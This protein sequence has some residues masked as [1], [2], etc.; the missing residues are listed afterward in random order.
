[1]ISDFFFGFEEQSQ[2]GVSRLCENTT[3]WLK[4]WSNKYE[5]WS[6][7][8]SQFSVSFLSIPPLR[9]WTLLCTDVLHLRFSLELWPHFL[10]LNRTP[11]LLLFLSHSCLEKER[12]R[13][14]SNKKLKKSNESET[15]QKVTTIQ[16]YFEKLKSFEW[17]YISLF[18]FSDS[19]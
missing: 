10:F 15:L 1:M 11:L 19:V 2:L 8:L 14:N 12:D 6:V 18:H 17:K 16:I 4:C 3:K 5:T 7:C 13:K 9:N